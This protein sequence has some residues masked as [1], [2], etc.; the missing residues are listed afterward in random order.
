MMDHSENTLRAA[1]K[2]LRDTV[3]PAVDPDDSQ[4]AEQLRLTIDFL[5][6]L[7]TRIYDVHARHR[8]EL[9]HQIEVAKALRS[10]ARLV[11]AMAATRLEDALLSAVERQSSADAHTIELRSAS[12]ELWGSVRGVVRAARDAADDVRERISLC[13]VQGVQPLVEMESA[14]YLPFGFEPN[15]T[16]IPGLDE[17]LAR[18]PD[19]VA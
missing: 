17:L 15:P 8:Y 12:Q 3:A 19:T 11:S 10:D 14:W 18:E 13:V 2:S 5:E 4:A 16:S 9:R 1:I 6:F 7:R